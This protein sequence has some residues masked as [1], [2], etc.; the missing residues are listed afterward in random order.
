MYVCV[1]CDSNSVNG[2]GG[3]DGVCVR[4]SVYVCV[5]V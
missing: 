5:S 2:H 4:E 1:W 3:F